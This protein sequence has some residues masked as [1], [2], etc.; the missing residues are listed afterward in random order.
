[1]PRIIARAEWAK[2]GGRADAAGEGAQL[3]LERRLRR[4]RDP[5]GR[6]R[7]RRTGLRNPQFRPEMIGVR[8]APRRLGPHRRHRHRA[9]STTDDFYVLEDNAAHAVR[10]LLHAGEPRSDD[11]AVPG[12]VRARTASR[13]SRIIPTSCSRRLRSVAP[14]RRRASRPWS[15]LTPGHLQFRLLR[16]LLPRRQ[17]RRRAGRGPR[18]VR[19]RDDVVYMRTTEGPQRVDVI[20][21][22]VDDDFL[23]PLA[24]RPDSHAGRARTDR[25]LSAGNVDARQR[26]RHRR[27]RRQGDLHATCRR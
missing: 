3:F 1:M 19:R 20:Y 22:R 18:P 13:R 5:A 17:A 4:A 26:D 2:A 16:A 11:A 24:F 15:L 25:R 12:S 10:R 14:A 8:R 27:R 23:D 9:R 6:R 21:R 7:A